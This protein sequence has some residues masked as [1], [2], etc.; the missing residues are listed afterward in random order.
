MHVV[1]LLLS[2]PVLDTATVAGALGE[3]TQN[4]CV[5]T[6]AN[7]QLTVELTKLKGPEEFA[8]FA[9]AACEGARGQTA[10]K[11]IGNEAVMCEF[12]NGQKLVSRVRDQGFTVLLNGNGELRKKVL[13]FGEQVAGNL[14]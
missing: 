8:H 4:E 13:L 1:L 12:A 5:F 7:Y 11:A 14:F 9:A 2:C 6:N 3:V 10:V